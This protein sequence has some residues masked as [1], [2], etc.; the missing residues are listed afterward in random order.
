MAEG[1]ILASDFRAK[2]VNHSEGELEIKGITGRVWGKM[3][4][5]LNTSPFPSNAI[6][7]GI[8][9]GIRPLLRS[10]PQGSLSKR[11]SAGNQIPKFMKLLE[12]VIVKLSLH[13]EV[14]R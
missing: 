3:T 5:F 6:I 13:R 4:H 14:H 11:P 8:S 2:Q 10:E 7:L 9:D 1:L 12:N